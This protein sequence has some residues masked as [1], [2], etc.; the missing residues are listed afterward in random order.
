MNKRKTSGLEVAVIGMAGR[1]PGAESLD[2]FWV[3]LAN[4]AESIKFFSR[5][6]LKRHGVD[7]ARFSD[8]NFV[9]AKAIID[10]AESF[11][12]KFFGYS[13]DEAATMDPQ[14]RVFHEIAWE[15]MEHAGY[16]PDDQ[17]TVG[18]YTG[19]SSNVYWQVATYLTRG[20]SVAEQF[21]A[22]Q[23]STGDNLNTRISYNL[24]LTGPSVLVNTACSSS[25]AAIH[26]ACR[27]LLT[28]ECE[29]ALAG[30]VSIVAP[31]VD[32]YVYSEGMILSPDGHCRPFDAQAE[33]SVP[34]E[35]VGVVVLKRLDAA[36]RDRD[37]IY[38]VILGSAMNNDGSR[39]VGYVAPSVQGQAEVIR[40]AHRMARIEPETISYI[41]AHGSGTRMGDPIELA[42]LADAFREHKLVSCKIGSVKS[43]IG[44]LDAAAGVAGFI[45][46]VLAL[47][48]GQVPPSLNFT[49]MNPAVDQ[50]MCRFRVNTE[51]VDWERGEQPR[52]AGVSSF[53]IGGTNV[54]VVLEEA[55]SVLHE[56]DGFPYHI[57]SW[58]ATSPRA[59]DQYT[60]HLLTYLKKDSGFQLPDISFTLNVGRK[61]M[62]HRRALVVT[63]I[64]EAVDKLA[65]LVHKTD[66]RSGIHT[67]ASRSGRPIYFVFPGQGSQFT[68]MGRE[69]FE[70]VPFFRDLM[71]ACFRELEAGTG[72]NFQSI[73]YPEK[74]DE[75]Q[76]AALRLKQTRYAQPLVF[77]FEYCLAR[78]LR[79]W[80]VV[81]SA[82]IGYSLGEYTAAC[83]SG[84]FSLQD[85]LKLVA[86]RGE[87]MQTAPLGE[88]LSV[89]MA[90]DEVKKM[91][92]PNLSL[93]VVNG[94]S[95]IVAGGADAIDRF[96]RKALAER[97]ITMKVGSAP[98]GHSLLM[99]SILEP[100][101]DILDPIQRSGPQIPFISDVTGTW[102]TD[103]DASSTAYWVRHLRDTVR[104]SDG[105][106]EMSQDPNAVF[107]EVGPGRNL[108]ALIRRFVNDERGDSIIDLVPPQDD[109]RS[110]NYLLSKLAR[111]WTMGIRVNWAAFHA[112]GLRSRV[113][114]PTYP[115]ER[116]VFE[117][118]AVGASRASEG[119]GRLPEL[120][121]AKSPKYYVPRWI[122]STATHRDESSCQR[123]CVFADTLGIADHV[124]SSL[125]NEGHEVIRVNLGRR[126]EQDGQ[127]FTVNPDRP[128]DY[129]ELVATWQQMACIPD[130]IGHFWNV[131]EPRG[132][133]AK[134]TSLGR[135]MER[136]FY[137]LLYLAQSLGK[138]G[139]TTPV[140]G[141]VFSS[142]MQDVFGDDIRH[143]EKALLLGAVK[144]IPSEYTNISLRSV[145]I[146]VHEAVKPGSRVIRQIV[147][148]LR[149]SSDE[150]VVAYR[151]NRRFVQSFAELQVDSIAMHPR[152]GGVY[153]ITGG[154][155][156]MGLALA[157]SL[158]RTHPV[159]LALISRHAL[160]SESRQFIRSLESNGT[161]V[162]TITADVTDP[163]QVLM[164]V[165]TILRRF[166]ALHGVVHCAGL[167]DG[168]LIPD[169]TSTDVGRVLAPKVQGV[170]A[171][172]EALTGLALDFLVLC[173]SLASILGG[174]G[175]VA[176]SAA[177]AFLD[178]MAHYMVAHKNIRAIAVNWDRWRNT[179]IAK[180]AEALHRRLTGE[181]LSGGISRSEGTTGFIT[182]LGSHSPQIAVCSPEAVFGRETPYFGEE[183]PP[184]D[185]PEPAHLALRPDLTSEYVPPQNEIEERLINLW[186][187][188]LGIVEIGRIDNFMELGGDSL[189]ALLMISQVR[190]DF[191]VNVSVPVFLAYPTVAQLAK[192]IADLE[193]GRPVP[194]EFIEPAELETSSAPPET[195]TASRLSLSDAEV[196]GIY[197]LTPMQEMV[198]SQ[199]LMTH[200]TGL[201]TMV[202]A[203]SINGSLD[204]HHLRDAWKD[205]IDHHSPLRTTFHWRRLDHP[206]QVVHVTADVPWTVHDW[207]H[208]SSREQRKLL[209]DLIQSERR[210]G[211]KVSSLP[212]MRLTLVRMGPDR[213]RLIWSFQN[214]LVDGWS[215]TLILQEVLKL[216]QYRVEGKPV[217]GPRANQF[218]SYVE[219]L[220]LHDNSQA[221]HYWQDAFKGLVV[222]PRSK[223]RHDMH[224]QNI[225]PAKRSLSLA[226]R[227]TAELIRYSQT[228]GLTLGAVIVAAWA[229]CLHEEEGTED[230]L[231][232]ITTSGR[233]ASVEGIDRTVGL[234]TNVMP[235]RI[236]FAKDPCEGNLPKYIQDQLASLTQ[237]DYVTPAQISKWTGLPLSTLRDAIY[238]KTLVLQAYPVDV[239]DGLPRHYGLSFSDGEFVGQTNVPL[240]LYVQPGD[241]LT[242]TLAYDKVQYSSTEMSDLLGKI[243]GHLTSLR[244]GHDV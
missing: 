40:A 183:A 13:H 78:L 74:E 169:R 9:P 93:A 209:R 134:M 191:S 184:L 158:A 225:V 97:I 141:A 238:H 71:Q 164:A 57:L 126:F 221:E 142:S 232:G 89:P 52:R 14:M 194:G 129:D 32:G 48:H 41:E 151:G 59:L 152:P 27:A 51:L 139:V 85:A 207:S 217:R 28:G 106:E 216:Y 130:H 162:L 62:E 189:K 102:I 190:K 236:P 203:C 202:F 127:T 125:R 99:D 185:M 137:S 118:R 116:K 242:F 166:G 133:D 167:P 213:H 47:Q 26:M 101:R 76:L 157:E 56:Q 223:P 178:S 119:W 181:E 17:R 240:R 235:L 237:Y 132:I 10:S 244:G 229:L 36:L 25:L 11:D 231:V 122:E 219:W 29:M 75:Q 136:G 54:H 83:L 138:F 115:F 96:E 24:N 67:A 16:V 39:K 105:I 68:N 224:I 77:A 2:E 95:C 46:T 188:L 165:S 180:P 211:F 87:L 30:G 174:P 70:K 60:E 163:D 170:I 145:D 168:A 53:G 86:V 182:L 161:H 94:K 123:W 233:T 176:Y 37:N 210:R 179:G 214:S 42:A 227:E 175:Q 226:R 144:S 149:H 79:E 82:M 64:Q 220:R 69:L 18:L 177:N 19:V 160:D 120:P 148:E 195:V 114:V 124:V 72:V 156:E 146:V 121:N 31:H 234:F 143:P 61:A 6:E 153:M 196:A 128:G 98:A 49:A 192:S 35:G 65:G 135:T 91:L 159:N 206:V 84:V 172:D 111:L 150:V 109:S 171:L 187:R 173:S 92:E 38:A 21:F 8:P 113:A 243:R 155:G 112:G 131:D 205:V 80:G 22:K 197:P 4:G 50:S 66:H 147:N 104:F 88:M 154:L 201:D 228:H 12:N 108:S 55:P 43:N 100:F 3:N 90:E 7:A 140:D 34:G 186:Q 218:S 208:Q 215:T 58:S 193:V 200:G 81:P 198:L 20:D 110:L 222:S 230:T 103:A 239:P 117:S 204:A 212:L 199:N 1:F 73:L 23:L 107:V 45:K 63:S 241:R 15:A 44:H 5:D 33:G